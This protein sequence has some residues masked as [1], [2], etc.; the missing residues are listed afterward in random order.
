MTYRQIADDLESRI[1]DGEFK[2]GWPLPL[3][4]QLGGLYGVSVS[5]AQRSIMLLRDRG[6]VSGV[7]GRGVFVRADLRV[8]AR[9]SA[10]PPVTED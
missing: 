2:P 5:T 4:A 3:I 9:A 7:P 1:H 10:P 6:L 8:T